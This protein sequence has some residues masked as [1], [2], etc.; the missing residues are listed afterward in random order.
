MQV[1]Q[2]RR[3]IAELVMDLDKNIQGVLPEAIIN[4]YAPVIKKTFKSV[5]DE[6]AKGRMFQSVTS[7]T[8]QSL[9]YDLTGISKKVAAN[10]EKAFT[11]KL[12]EALEASIGDNSAYGIASQIVKGLN[13]VTGAGGAQAF[14]GSFIKNRIVDTITIQKGAVLKQQI[15]KL[16]R[17][18]K[19]Q[20]SLFYETPSTYNFSALHTGRMI[21]SEGVA[22]NTLD[23]IKAAVSQ[24][25]MRGVAN[26]VV[27][28]TAELDKR[29]RAT[30][31][32][33]ERQIRGSMGGFAKARIQELIGQGM[34]KAQAKALV[35]TPAEQDALRHMALES[36]LGGQNYA[37]GNQVRNL[38][39]F[40]RNIATLIK[41]AQASEAK[42]SG[43]AAYFAGRK[44][45]ADLKVAALKENA[46]EEAYMQQ[47]EE[48][49][50]NGTPLSSGAIRFFE[51]NF[52][53][54]NGEAL[55]SKAIA[56]TKR[57]LTVRRANL[58]LAQ[59]I[60]ADKDRYGSD[61]PEVKWAR[62]TLRQDKDLRR[63]GG[64]L[65]RVFGGL[66]PALIP[67]IAG[68]QLI[69]KLVGFINATV[70]KIYKA[71]D[72]TTGKAREQQ[73]A[74]DALGITQPQLQWAE[75]MK[76]AYGFNF[77]GAYTQ[78]AK[79]LSDIISNPGGVES[80]ITAMG[81]QGNTAAI[82]AVL[83]QS[84]SQG[85]TVTATHGAI[86]GALA[87]ALE[88]KSIYGGNVTPEQALLQWKQ[89]LE[90]Y[91][92]S[93]NAVLL[94]QMFTQAKLMSPESRTDLMQQIRQGN[95]NDA[96]AMVA[97]SAGSAGI[98][99]MAAAS[100]V[101]RDG[102][103]AMGRALSTEAENYKSELGEVRKQMSLT[104][105]QTFSDLK[106]FKEGLALGF[107]HFAAGTV[108]SVTEASSNAEK[109]QRNREII[110]QA[111]VLKRQN[112]A[113]ISNVLEGEGSVLS[114]L[115]DKASLFK[116][117]VNIGA[118]TGDYNEAFREL[119][120]IASTNGLD[121]YQID[122]LV[123][124][125]GAVATITEADKAIAQATK[126]NAKGANGGRVKL[127]L[128][129]D[130]KT[131]AANAV[132]AVEQSGYATLNEY[133]QA[134]APSG[135][136]SGGASFEQDMRN[137]DIQYRS[138]L[139]TLGLNPDDPKSK[140]K[141]N[142][143]LALGGMV[144]SGFNMGSDMAQVI[145]D[146]ATEGFKASASDIKIKDGVL[147]IEFDDPNTGRSRSIEQTVGA[148]YGS[149]G[150]LAGVSTP[151]LGNVTEQVKVSTGRQLNAYS[152]S[153]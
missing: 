62:D 127:A 58:S 92:G 49:K 73:Q 125:M 150:N 28:K 110:A 34:G 67:I 25:E 133:A 22:A 60:M 30:G 151:N 121:A 40:L 71:I 14:G 128:G 115:G 1:T 57:M 21:S 56:N 85:D 78:T 9:A 132:M 11:M 10:I 31:L 136:Y 89:Q 111:E 82:G 119:F 88:G 114:N 84:M 79:S 50:R 3:L 103:A 101:M 76:N 18:L 15:D 42:A 124:Y 16:N 96:I 97:N 135:G 19:G 139:I 29:G 61:S 141:F 36:I 116:R 7:G 51:Q 68:V 23:Y 59:Q 126:F 148:V 52:E 147:R 32:V 98:V 72:Q 17:E 53:L 107:M 63:G 122:Q 24:A 4:Q 80:F 44:T 118:S 20:G 138:M 90:K 65:G 69:G 112:E 106:R 5:M 77:T 91:T 140:Y 6:F 117:H 33:T 145:K 41:S 109:Y 99:G 144:S 83:R 95:V 35:A 2:D 74:V 104:W 129:G 48:F 102:L 146:A 113:V 137:R 123:A 38:P 153:R 93:E 94:G 54:D 131:I 66:P 108:S 100:D 39:P 87:N 105:G 130:I 64:L 149:V 27:N 75:S 43:D 12:G 26:E 37:S 86:A 70:D 55:S 13:V 143:Q 46:K 142:Q 120:N 134:P 47:L 8:Q 152:R 45:V 81:L